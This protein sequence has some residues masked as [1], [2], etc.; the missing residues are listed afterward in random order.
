M[1]R[2]KNGIRRAARWRRAV[3]VGLAALVLGV[4]ASAAIAE[5]TRTVKLRRCGSVQATY[6][7][8]DVYPWHI[9]CAAARHLI[10]ASD[11]R[12]VRTIDFGPGWDGGAV[13]VDGTWWVCTGQM[14]FYNCGWP[15][16]PRRVDGERGYGGPFTKDVEFQAC[17]AAGSYGCHTTSNLVLPRTR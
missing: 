5:S 7:R 9:S 14:G 12:G 15:Y 2:I 10:V 13:R 8:S 11:R 16:R 1:R 17:S 4:V 6:G 3:S